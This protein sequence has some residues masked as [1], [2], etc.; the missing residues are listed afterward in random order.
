[1]APKKPT[2]GHNDPSDDF[3]LWTVYFLLLAWRYT[4]AASLRTFF[5]PDEY[6]QA[7]EPAWN[8]AFGP[9]SGAW[10]TWEWRE[11]LRSSLHPVLFAIFY[12]AAEV[13]SNILDL[14][15][16]DRAEVLIR[17]PSLL[18]S[19]IAAAIDFST[20]RLTHRIYGRQSKVTHVTLF[21]TVVSPWQWF[22]SVRT[23]S[24]SLETALTVFALYYWPWDWYSEPNEKKPGSWSSGKSAIK[25]NV[26]LFA[27]ALACILRPTN[28]LVWM[29]LTFM[30]FRHN[31]SKIQ[32]LAFRAVAC[33]MIV[34]IVSLVA[35]TA[36]YGKLTFPPLNFLQ[37]NVV[38]SL[39]TFYGVNRPDYYFTEALSLMLTTALPFA[40]IGLWQGLRRPTVDDTEENHA[41]QLRYL[42][43]WTVLTMVLVLTLIT[44]KEV[45]FIYPLLPMLHVIAAEPMANFFHPLPV[46]A[47][48]TRRALLALMMTAN[49]LI[50]SYAG[51]THQRGVI[52]VMHYLR[53]QQEARFQRPPT[54]SQPNITVGFLMPCHST[55]WRSHLVHPEIAAWALTCEPPI[56]IPPE[57]RAT[58]LDEADV[59]YKTSAEDWLRSN[60]ASADTIKRD[61]LVT[62]SDTVK[63]DKLRDWPEYLAFFDQLVPTLD[64]Y[65]AGTRYTECWRGFN[66]HWHDD[67]RRYGD[68]VVWCLPTPEDRERQKI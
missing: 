48:Y 30:L 44:H 32:T 35:D 67:S 60:M 9:E 49:L 17:A 2:A 16:T 36:F 3:T 62:S 15:P 34:L 1:M 40:A 55:P 11:G 8:L 54:G 47:S 24:N 31:A 59:F 13:S 6:F 50:A 19:A 29:V 38:Q 20:W 5:Q 61:S 45:R 64:N 10:I 23:F 22:C 52:D 12:K 42:L 53:K 63:D 56:D 14:G 18:Q 68:V 4:N 65:L 27:A 25:L 66:T 37:F 26:S 43:T 57:Q 58:Y 51:T 39:S 28:V 21:L 46:P 7:L 41:R 33:G